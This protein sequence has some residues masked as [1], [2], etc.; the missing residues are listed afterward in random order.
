[1]MPQRPT[2]V[3][4]MRWFGGQC[5]PTTGRLGELDPSVHR[6]TRDDLTNG[7]E[8]QIACRLEA[9]T[10]LAHVE[11]LTR[12][13][14]A[15]R[16]ASRERAITVDGHQVQR[17]VRLLRR[18]RYVPQRVSV[19]G[20]SVPDEGHVL[21]QHALADGLLV[22][23]GKVPLNLSP[24]ALDFWSSIGGELC[25]ELLNGRARGLWSHGYESV[26]SSSWSA[27]LVIQRRSGD[28]G[29]L[30]TSSL[31]S[32]TPARDHHVLCCRGQDSTGSVSQVTAPTTGG[33]TCAIGQGHATQILPGRRHWLSKSHQNQNGITFAPCTGMTNTPA[34]PKLLDQVRQACRLRHF[35]EPRTPTHTGRADSSSIRASAIPPRSAPRR[36]QPSLPTSPTSGMS[37]HQRRI[38]PSARFTASVSQRP[39]PAP[40]RSTRIAASSTSDTPAGDGYDI[41]TVQELLG[42]ADV[43]TTMIYTHVLNRGGRGVRSP[44][45]NL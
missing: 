21:H 27:E 7:I 14:E 43:S 10:R 2:A 17:Q 38:R 33:R 42:H 41:R 26:V 44:A 3:G 34:T 23:R 19:V 36:S 12:R 24:Y 45:D 39:A 29:Q 18:Q 15:V 32:L 20:V 9:N 5:L 13:L 1:M 37:A 40:A 11:L 16:Q 6:D 8:C 4:C 31:C 30:H 28:L 22:S 35:A 25:E